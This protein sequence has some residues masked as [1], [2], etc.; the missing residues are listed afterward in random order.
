MFAGIAIITCDLSF[1]VCVRVKFLV[2]CSCCLGGRLSRSFRF[3]AM[4]RLM[5]DL[6]QILYNTICLLQPTSS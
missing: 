3:R 1:S 5:L 4:V 6:I 2:S